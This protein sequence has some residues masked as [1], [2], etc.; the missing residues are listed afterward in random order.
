MV[1]KASGRDINS[2]NQDDKT[3]VEATDY[4]N[5]RVKADQQKAYQQR[6][7]LLKQQYKSDVEA[8][9]YSTKAQE[10]SAD[11]NDQTAKL[12]EMMAGL[13]KDSGRFGGM[14]TA[15]FATYRANKVTRFLDDNNDDLNNKQLESR[16]NTDEQ[17]NEAYDKAYYIQDRSTERYKLK[18]QGQRLKLD[19]SDDSIKKQRLT[20]KIDELALQAKKLDISDS[21]RAISRKE[22]GLEGRGLDLEDKQQALTDRRRDI[23]NDRRKREAPYQRREIQRNAADAQ[24][25][26]ILSLASAPQFKG[27][28]E[29]IDYVQDAQFAAQHGGA[30]FLD[31][32]AKTRWEKK[33]R[34]FE[35]MMDKKAQSN[36][37]L[38]NFDQD[39]K[40]D[41]EKYGLENSAADLSRKK[42]GLT[43]EQLANKLATLN[44]DDQEAPDKRKDLA[45]EQ[46]SAQNELKG[47]DLGEAER[48][49]A[50]IE[51]A[52]AQQR[53]T[54]QTE[55]TLEA[56]KVQETAARLQ[57]KKINEDIADLQNGKKAAIQIANSFNIPIDAKILQQAGIDPAGLKK[58]IQEGVESYCESK[59][60][61]PK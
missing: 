19:T 44:L 14:N 49:V 40:D 59:G 27:A 48:Y 36:G 25:A 23:E 31:Q 55:K 12:D 13:A 11:H 57:A 29:S 1:S 33:N 43:R 6:S 17:R 38:G 22:L 24:D 52:R 37:A 61:K 18:L 51:N 3:G 42:R 4:A 20:L 47:L 45:L 7:K 34:D 56:F 15:R 21:D 39:Q 10:E 9:D 26:P 32:Y 5:S 41:D 58:H 54:Q 28:T 60:R 46:K 50:T 16:K 8:Y 53:F 30:D 35:A 2:S